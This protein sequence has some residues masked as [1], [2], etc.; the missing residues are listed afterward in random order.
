LIDNSSNW[1]T[2]ANELLRS[3]DWGDRQKVAEAAQF[4]TSMLTAFYGPQSPQLEAFQCDREAIA[5]SKD[6]E[7]TRAFGLSLLA[8][9]TIANV[10]AELE[11]G[12]IVKLRALVAGEIL[13]ELVRLG[14]EILDEQT[15]AAK[16]VAAVMT[17]AALEDLIRRLGLELGGVTD[18]RSLQD[19]ITSL[20]S[21][22]V[23][24]GGEIG[25]AQ[26]F[27]QFRND[28]LHADWAKV[29]RVQVESCIAFIES[30]LVKHF[31]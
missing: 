11:A 29:S 15:D 3:A 21:V 27:L 24:K 31:S 1:I 10:K 30:M 22:G 13:A 25:I 20:K 12:L 19:V 26:S 4:A 8:L 9:G 16:N 28:S 14:K 6:P 23:L 18:R 5:K 17:A 7:S 2:R